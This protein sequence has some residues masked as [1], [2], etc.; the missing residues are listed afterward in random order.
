M[1]RG[2]TIPT[3]DPPPPLQASAGSAQACEKFIKQLPRIAVSIPALPKESGADRDAV[4]ED[5][6]GAASSNHTIS[7]TQSF[8]TA[9]FLA[10][11]KQAVSVGIFA[12]LIPASSLCGP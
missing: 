7:T 10:E 4:R 2:R 5:C 6:V 9:D 12:G 8:Q 1:A 11:H 3:F